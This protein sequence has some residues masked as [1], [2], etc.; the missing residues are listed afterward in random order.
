MLL[1]SSV[2]SQHAEYGLFLRDLGQVYAAQN[3]FGDAERLL[4]ES[5]PILEREFG[6]KDLR[7]LET[8]A[9]YE[10]ARRALGGL[11]GSGM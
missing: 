4:G 3:N 1:E 11:P 9:S 8:R 5:L 10:A 7:V 6:P 2:G